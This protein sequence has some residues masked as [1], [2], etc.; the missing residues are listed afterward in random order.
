MQS[1]YICP[2]T[3]KVLQEH[4]IG[5][6]RDDGVLYPY[7][8]N[9]KGNVP[10]FLLSCQQGEYAKQSLEMYN[11]KD[12]T[13]IY[14][15]FLDWLFKTFDEEET[16]FRKK[17]IAK[18]QLKNGDKVLI[19]GCGLGD[20]IYPILDIIGDS[21]EVYAS[22]LSGEM[23]LAATHH[24]KLSN[25]NTNNI[26]FSV[27]NAQTLPFSDDFFDGVFHFGGINLFDDIELAIK[28]MQ[29]V[30]K[31]GARVVFGDEGV[32]P[33]LKNTEYGKIAINNNSLWDA[34]PPINLLPENAL[35]VNLSWILGGCFYLIDFE[36]SD[37]GPYMNMNI[38]H[39]GPRG[40][41][42][43]TRYFGKL[44]GVS[45]ETK[46]FVIAD[47]K[48]KG[49]SAHDWLEQIINKQRENK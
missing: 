45:L 12:S 47:A 43:G 41:N 15:N 18:L 5:L 16:L 38:N 46:Q 4:D 48:E 34:E 39:K 42:M 20:D 10:N 19:T 9:I 2:K 35:D 49:I 17:L 23:I 26:Y 29:R 3:K 44:E 21:G 1:I 28:E 36:V 13:D 14:A 24:K 40:G 37:V 7:I 22:D 32:A 31:S 33:W 30:A 11:Q 25:Y 27:C 6:L 8:E